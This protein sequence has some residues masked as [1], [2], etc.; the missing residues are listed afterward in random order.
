M[1]DIVQSGGTGGNCGNRL[2]PRG[3]QQF[4]QTDLVGTAPAIICALRFPPVPTEF[5]PENEGKKKMFYFL[6]IVLYDF[7]L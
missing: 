5:P 6:S 2:E 1:R 7:Y 4:P 3:F